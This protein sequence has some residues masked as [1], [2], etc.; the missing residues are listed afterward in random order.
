MWTDIWGYQIWQGSIRLLKSLIPLSHTMALMLSK[1]TLVV[2]KHISYPIKHILC[3]QTQICRITNKA[4]EVTE[5]YPPSISSIFSNNIRKHIALNWIAAYIMYTVGS[6]N[7]MLPCQNWWPY[8][9][10]AAVA[11]CFIR[12]INSL[13]I[14]RVNL[15]NIMP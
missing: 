4:L 2:S 1:F 15:S 7:L 13:D 3:E 9:I 8:Y 11:I 12:K 6:A 14:T 5:I 10:S